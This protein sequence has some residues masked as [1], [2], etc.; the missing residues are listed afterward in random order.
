[1]TPFGRILKQLVEKTPGALGGAFADSQG[2]MVDAFA[3]AYN[4]H[5]F[6]VITAHYGVVL[7]HLHAVFGVW[8]FG[9]PE[10][11]VC[12]HTKMSLVVVAVSKHYF[13]LLALTDPLA[14]P[15]A[16]ARMTEAAGALRQEM[17]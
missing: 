12:Q 16:L 4:A 10:Y 6:A 7:G 14:V 11:F 3:P 9:G 2:E 15:V 13:A 8:H 5:D 1:M 17:L